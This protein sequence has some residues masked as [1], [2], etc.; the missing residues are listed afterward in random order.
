[1]AYLVD[2]YAKND[3]LYPKDPKQRAA[4]DQK[5]YFDITFYSY[6]AGYYVSKYLITKKISYFTICCVTVSSVIWS[7]QRV[8]RRTFTTYR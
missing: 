4:V 2:Q 5:L 6:L 1:M 8:Q 7:S 3:A